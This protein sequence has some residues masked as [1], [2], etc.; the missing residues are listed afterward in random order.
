M[1]SLTCNTAAKGCIEAALVGSPRFHLREAL[2]GGRRN[3]DPQALSGIY[4]PTWSAAWTGCRGLLAGWI[5]AGS[6]QARGLRAARCL[7]LAGPFEAPL[8]LH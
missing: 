5:G 2:Y 7:L 1:C 3:P 4:T 6:H 8:V